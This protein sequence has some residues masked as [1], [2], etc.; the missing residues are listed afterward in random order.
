MNSE[1][2]QLPQPNWQYWELHRTITP[3][4]ILLTFIA[5]VL[6]SWSAHNTEMDKA[7]AETSKAVLSTIGIGKS[8][9]L[10]GAL[11]FGGQ[12]FPIQISQRTAVNRLENFDS[13][14]L[15]WLSYMK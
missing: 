2:K 15:P 1:T 3:K 9:V 5:F 7:F 8:Q 12:A 11:R 6:L 10:D 4:T 13:D 14:N